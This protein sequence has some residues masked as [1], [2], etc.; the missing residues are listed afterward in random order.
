[1]FLILI[2]RHGKE[3]IILHASILSKITQLLC[4]LVRALRELQIAKD[5]EPAEYYAAYLQRHGRHSLKDGER[6]R[7]KD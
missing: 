2:L 7:G 5:E 4:K 3:N 6:L 1:M